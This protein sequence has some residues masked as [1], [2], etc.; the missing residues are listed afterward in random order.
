MKNLLLLL[1]FGLISC[2]I[3]DFEREAVFIPYLDALDVYF[4]YV[5]ID[6]DFNIRFVDNLQDNQI[7]VWTGISVNVNPT[8][9]HKLNYHAKLQALSHEIVG[10]N[11]LNLP[12][13]HPAM[14]A[15]PAVVSEEQFIKYAAVLSKI[16]NQGGS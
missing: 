2:S 16:H 14:Y 4:E 5:P 15:T 9:F 3:Q 11:I 6:R 1:T 7:A 12:E 10:H 8:V 13:S